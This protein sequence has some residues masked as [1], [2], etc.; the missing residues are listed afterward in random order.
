ME[1]FQPT[2][3]VSS[4]PKVMPARVVLFTGH[5]VDREDTDPPRFPEALRDR[6][7]DAIRDKL[8]Q[9]IA[10]TDGP[11]VGIA[12]GANGGDLLF[13]EVC[14]ELKVEHRLYLATPAGQVSQR[15]GI[16]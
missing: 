3:D 8:Q 4:P 2:A 7:R 12:S 11:V 10:R 9:E 5:M 13:H 15:I 16:S 1:V 14:E 6:A